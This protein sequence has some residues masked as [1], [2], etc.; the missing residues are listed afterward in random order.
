MA[1]G[2]PS[3]QHVVLE[4][5]HKCLPLKTQ[6]GAG[7]IVCASSTQLLVLSCVHCSHCNL[8]D[9][10]LFVSTT[11]LRKPAPREVLH[12]GGSSVVVLDDRERLDS[13]CRFRHYW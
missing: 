12:G 3:R 9:V 6:N 2:C 7:L 4:S 1:P 11:A 8:I 10:M 13:S 5:V